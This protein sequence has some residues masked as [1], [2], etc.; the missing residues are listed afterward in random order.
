MKPLILFAIATALLVGNAS[1]ASRTENR[2]EVRNPWSRPAAA[3]MVGVGYM[4][5]VNPGARPEALVSVESP[6][7]NRVEI[8]RSTMEHGVMTMSPQARVE[9]PAGGSVAFAPGGYHLMFIGLKRELKPGDKLP[10]TLVFEGGRR[11]RI[12]FSVGNGGP[13]TARHRGA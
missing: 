6:A 5:L 9:T 8:H 7:A 10:A 12:E 13:P 4:T 11:I 1:A 2:V 3:G